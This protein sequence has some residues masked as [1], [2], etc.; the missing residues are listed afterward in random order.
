MA[1]SKTDPTYFDP[2]TIRDV[3]I[4]GK[5]M[6]NR[7]K[8]RLGKFKKGGTEDRRFRDFFGT[9]AACALDSW[10]RLHHF[11]LTPGGGRF[12]HLLWALMFMKIYGKEADL[13]AHAGDTSG[14]VDPKTYRKWVWPFVEALAEM[15]YN[16]VS[17]FV[18][19][20]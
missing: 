2:I 14:L 3:H 1:R 6:M 12:Y 8:K 18:S 19:L 10:H 15:E 20:N 9:F 16:V 7:G 17:C 13:C 11:Q 5:E 4:M